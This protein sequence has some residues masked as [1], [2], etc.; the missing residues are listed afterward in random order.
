MNAL[1]T[2]EVRSIEVSNYDDIEHMIRACM[3]D[4]KSKKWSIELHFVQFQNIVHFIKQ[5]DTALMKL[6]FLD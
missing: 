5:L 1:K 6:F 4:N 2:L 3:T